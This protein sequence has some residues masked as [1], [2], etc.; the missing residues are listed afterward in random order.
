MPIGV[1][2]VR[3]YLWVDFKHA[4]VIVA[5]FFQYFHIAKLISVS[6]VKSTWEIARL[7]K[8]A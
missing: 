4:D 6:A 7:P 8:Q 3:S 5:G 1:I 2:H